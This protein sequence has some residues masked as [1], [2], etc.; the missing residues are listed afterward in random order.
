MGICYSSNEID[1]ISYKVI[2]FETETDYARGESVT[3]NRLYIPSIGI[4]VHEYK[5]KIIIFK[6]DIMLVTGKTDIKQTTIN[7]QFLNLIMKL[8]RLQ[9]DEYGLSKKIACLFKTK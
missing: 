3:L 9:Q 4:H 7:K 8:N 2:A 5:K 6:Q 1:A